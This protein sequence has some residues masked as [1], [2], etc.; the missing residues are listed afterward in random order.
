MPEKMP[1]AWKIS[2]LLVFSLLLACQKSPMTVSLKAGEDTILTACDPAS[3]GSGVS[4]T[5]AVIIAENTREIRVFGLDM[6]FDPQ[7]FQFS[8]VTSGNLT[9]SWAAVDGNEI[10]PGTLRI[11]GFA[12]GAGSITQKS[13]G[14]LAI[15]HLQ[16]KATNYSHN[17]TAQVCIHHYTDDLAPFQPA[18][19][20]STFTL[21]K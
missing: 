15:V 11:G 17:Q 19:A 16:V 9:G 4:L 10:T 1:G 6:S 18:S 13:Q 5:V 21:K 14:G 12:G 3:G 2:L 8:K 20:C 7:I